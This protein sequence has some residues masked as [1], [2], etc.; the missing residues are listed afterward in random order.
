LRRSREESRKPNRGL[1][2]RDENAKKVGIERT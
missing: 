2:E 1:R